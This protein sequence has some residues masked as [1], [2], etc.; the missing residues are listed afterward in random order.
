MKK[1]LFALLLV[2]LI[3]TLILGACTETSSTS[4]TEPA[5]TSSTSTTKPIE[6]T[7]T[8]TT[9][10]VETSSATTTTT[11]EPIVLKLVAYVGDI[12][13]G[14]IWTNMLI[15]KV[16]EKSNG[17]LIIEYTGGP[18][19]IPPPDAPAAAQ[20]GTIDIVNGAYPLVPA[21]ATAVECLAWS[22][23]S[24]ADVRNG[25]GYDLAQELF[26]KVN[27][28]FL[29]HSFVTGSQHAAAFF[30]NVKTEKPEDFAGLNIALPDPGMLGPCEALGATPVVIT[31]ADFY[32]AM[33]RGT[34][35]AF[36]LG[37]AGLLDWSL[38][39]VTDYVI[40][41]RMN[42]GGAGF[43]VN[44]DVWNKLPKNLQDVMIESA[45]EVEQEGIDAFDEMYDDLL[46][47]AK[48]AGMEIINFSPS[49]SVSF[50]D[51]IKDAVWETLIKQYPD[52]GPR[53]KELI[54]P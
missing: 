10:P 38:Q 4:T 51:T 11:V 36:W 40:D 53:F 43:M 37:V 9:K 26:D 2:L 6:T 31:Q 15:D 27:I 25:G 54:A 1:M 52:Y 49:D 20:R 45:T 12:P 14:N 23:V 7:S 39:D 34:V 28:F 8:S 46:L 33:E 32:T 21:P 44:L 19:V 16:K 5:K 29:G 18:E 50:H 17:A 30:S 35:D 42:S 47:I 41:E 3:G 22:E 24:Y 48:D 13:P